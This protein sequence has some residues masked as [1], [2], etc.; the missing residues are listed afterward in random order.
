MR[1]KSNEE[2]KRNNVQCNKNEPNYIKIHP[3]VPMRMMWISL[4]E[5]KA[6]LSSTTFHLP[7]KK[8]LKISFH[9]LK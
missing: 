1:L 3:L 4:T 2:I 7:E 6:L 5:N 8:R 9:W